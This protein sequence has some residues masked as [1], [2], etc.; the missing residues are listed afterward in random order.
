MK[1]LFALLLTTL[2]W[3]ALAAGPAVKVNVQWL[4]KDFPVR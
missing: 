4:Y 2:A 3:P 1:R